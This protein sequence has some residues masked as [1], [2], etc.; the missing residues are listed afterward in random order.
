MFEKNEKKK[1]CQKGFSNKQT[2]I[3]E[4]KLPSDNFQENKYINCTF[5]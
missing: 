2:E 5:C 3:T 1:A 4:Y